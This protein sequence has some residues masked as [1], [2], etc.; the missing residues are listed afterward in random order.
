MS[1]TSDR[2]PCGEQGRTRSPSYQQNATTGNHRCVAKE[3]SS[4]NV[5]GKLKSQTDWSTPGRIRTCNPRFRRPMRYPVAP[6]VQSIPKVRTTLLT[7]TII[8]K[9][10]SL[11]KGFRAGLRPTKSDQGSRVVSP[12]KPSEKLLHL[13]WKIHWVPVAFEVRPPPVAP[14]KA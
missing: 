10:E 2:S 4:N 14:P 5:P 11:L 12:Q 6:R 7:P 9:T 3:R 1:W 13:A 8:A